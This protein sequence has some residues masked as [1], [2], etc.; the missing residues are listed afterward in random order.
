MMKSMLDGEA[1]LIHE[2]GFIER[3]QATTFNTVF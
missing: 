1:F 2:G 3:L